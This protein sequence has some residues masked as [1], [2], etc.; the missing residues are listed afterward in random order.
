MKSKREHPPNPAAQALGRLRMA[1]LTAPARQELARKG[2]KGRIGAM[3]AEARRE[4]S[5]AGARARWAKAGKV[6]KTTPRWAASI[7]ASH[8]EEV[9]MA[10]KAA[11]QQLDLD[12]LRA[13]CAQ[14]TSVAGQ[15]KE[16]GLGLSHWSMI[17]RGLVVVGLLPRLQ[18]LPGR[19][20]IAVGISTVR[21]TFRST[22]GAATVTLRLSPLGISPG[23]RVRVSYEA[24]RIVITPEGKAEIGRE[25]AT[26]AGE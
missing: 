8:G 2:G 26:D 10:T 6:K 4:I 25:P 3:T 13:V 1:K 12:H 22:S 9:K 16:L 18:G 14:V 20:R 5:A 11:T 17:R 21:K 15:A 19:P 23:D 24:D 7:G